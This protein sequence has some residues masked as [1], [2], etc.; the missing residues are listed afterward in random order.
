MVPKSSPSTGGAFDLFLE[1]RRSAAVFFPGPVSC[2][3]EQ[4]R[5]KRRELQIAPATRVLGAV[6]SGA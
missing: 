1:L 5:R 2:E 6:G 3:R 4:G